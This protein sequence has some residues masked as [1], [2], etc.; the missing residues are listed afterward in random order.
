[1]HKIMLSINLK[2]NIFLILKSLLVL[3]FLILLF[4]FLHYFFFKP[5]PI[6]NIITHKDIDRVYV[7][8]MERSVER[9]KE[10]EDVLT[11]HFGKKLFGKDFEEI[12]FKCTDAKSTLMI[13]NKT[14]NEKYN[15]VEI[16]KGQKNF[17]YDNLYY[18]YDIQ[19]P[20]FVIKYKP[21]RHSPIMTIGEIGA[22]MS[23][24]RAIRDI[25]KNDYRNGIIFED[26]F[27]FFDP[28]NF[29]KD[30]DTAFRHTPAGYDVI[31]FDIHTENISEQAKISS[32]KTDI[33]D[34]LKNGKNKYF[35]RL[36]ENECMW[37]MTAYLVSN[38]GAKQ[39][40]NFVENKLFEGRFTIDVPLLYYDAP[41]EMSDFRL[42][43]KKIPLISQKDV[44][45]KRRDDNSSEVDK[46]SVEFNNKKENR[47]TN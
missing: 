43:Y 10:Y 14:N 4:I 28:D 32:I 11:K 16:L 24:L 18:I 12:R 35:N 9:R 19:E 23:H 13:D 40:I 30:F 25:V 44:V 29:Y 31:K 37:M 7:L 46:L 39:I 26:D 27:Y 1:M 42:Y 47:R 3:L 33:R 15:A 5:R 17:I 38:K 8:N 2:K 41:R 34:Y 36:A 22:T 20:D 6:T 21:N 45:E